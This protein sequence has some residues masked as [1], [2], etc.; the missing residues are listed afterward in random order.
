MTGVFQKKSF[1]Q[2]HNFHPE[3]SH[4]IAL[5][6]IR[7]DEHESYNSAHLSFRREKE[8]DRRWKITS[9]PFCFADKKAAKVFPRE[10]GGGSISWLHRVWIIWRES[11]TPPRQHLR[12]TPRLVCVCA[13]FVLKGPRR[14]SETTRLSVGSFVAD[15][16]F[17]QEGSFDDLAPAI[18]MWCVES[19]MG[20]IVRGCCMYV[21]NE[22][23][24]FDVYQLLIFFLCYIIIYTEKYYWIS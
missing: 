5:P 23:V 19:L 16:C 9:P 3:E 13:K 7:E 8:A 12:P 4:H 11:E 17:I 18:F 20:R 15:V 2:I 22:H 14:G 6:S 24:M 1:I 10:N 21:L